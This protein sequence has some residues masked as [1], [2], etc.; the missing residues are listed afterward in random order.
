MTR[1]ERKIYNYE[2]N[3]TIIDEIIYKRC[4][5]HNEFLIMDEDNF[6][7]WDHSVD[8]FHPQCRKCNIERQIKYQKNN[9][10]HVK[11]YDKQRYLDKPEYYKENN[12]KHTAL[13]PEHYRNKEREWAR[14]HPDKIKYYSTYR[15]MHKQHDIIEEE[16]IDCKEFFNYECAFCG[17]IE[18]EAKLKYKNKLHKEH[19]I[20]DGSNEIDNCV[21]ACK[22]CNSSK[23]KNDWNIWYN[24]NNPRFNQKRYDKIEEWLNF[25][26]SVDALL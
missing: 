13:K 12:K 5:K 4:T 3:H 20:N 21:P 23:R 22:S 14:N 1:E 15:E 25:Y 24:E 7:R 26:D 17:I 10:E 2:K 6:Y 18:E 19:A 11:E 16:W 9:I 8:G